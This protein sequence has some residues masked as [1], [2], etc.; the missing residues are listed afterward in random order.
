MK[1][2]YDFLE[3]TFARIVPLEINPIE[4]ALFKKKKQESPVPVKNTNGSQ[5]GGM[6]SSGLYGLT[7]DD[8]F[9]K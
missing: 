3:E 8:S 4:K 5:S 7:V 9:R 6:D 2:Y 1:S